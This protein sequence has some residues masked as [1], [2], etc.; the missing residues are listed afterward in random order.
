MEVYG[1]C[2]RTLRGAYVPCRRAGSGQCVV[3]PG[4]SEEGTMQF[5]DAS[6]PY[7]PS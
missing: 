5:R 3:A 6:L 1:S 2:E 4:S 7:F